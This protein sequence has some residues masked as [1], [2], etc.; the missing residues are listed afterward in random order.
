MLVSRWRR[1][2]ALYLALFFCAVVAAPHEHI[3][4]LEDL[5][6]DQPSD[7]GVIEE[8]DAQPVHGSTVAPPRFVHDIP[9]PACFTSDFVTTAASAIAVVPL[10]TPLPRRPDPIPVS[11]L[12]PPP[13][14]SV[15]RAP[16][17]A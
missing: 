11:R 8:P 2:A 17:S 16:P 1:A 10:L 13:T 14:D 6:L 9:C 12:E 15:S 5:L 7:S 3:N 4:G